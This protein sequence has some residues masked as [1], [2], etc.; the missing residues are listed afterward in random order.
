MP[1]APSIMPA[2]WLPRSPGR[3]WCQLP[4]QGANTGHVGHIAQSR[5]LQLPPL[6]TTTLGEIAHNG[7]NLYCLSSFRMAIPRAQTRR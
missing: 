5:R 4:N 7:S 3:D 6:P 1:G 2:R